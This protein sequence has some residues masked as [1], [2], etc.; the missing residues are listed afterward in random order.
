MK[1]VLR[2]LYAS[3]PEPLPF[4]PKLDARAFLLR[5]PRGNLVLYRAATVEGERQALLELGGVSRQYLNHRHE[6][7]PVCDWVAATFDAPVHCHEA[8]APGVREICTV[9]GTFSARQLLDDDFEII[10]IPGHTPG[11]TAYLWDTGEHRLLFAGDSLQPRAEGW[12]AVVLGGAHRDRY[13]ESLELIRTLD[14]DVVVP[15]V[16]SAGQ[17][18]YTPVGRAEIERQLDAV[19]ARI[20]R[21]ESH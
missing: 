17:P 18:F 5:R 1:E 10:P 9:G 11:A 3:P 2:G 19:L 8:D 15:W 20:R 16:A 4:G 6:A 7:A 14:F 12:I 21:G 13:V